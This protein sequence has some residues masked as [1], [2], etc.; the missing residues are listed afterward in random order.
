LDLPFK[1]E[2][3]SIAHFDKQYDCR[4]LPIPKLRLFMRHQC[5]DAIISPGHSTTV[6]DGHRR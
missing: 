1:L 5:G 2:M 6:I 3:V 4:S